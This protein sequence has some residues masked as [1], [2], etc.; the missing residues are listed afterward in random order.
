MDVLIFVLILSNSGD[1][2][3]KKR[4]CRDVRSCENPSRTYLGLKDDLTFSYVSGSTKAKAA[5]EKIEIKGHNGTFYTHIILIQ[6][7][8]FVCIFNEQLWFCLTIGRQKAS[9]IGDGV[10]FYEVTQNALDVIKLGFFSCVMGVAAGCQTR[11]CTPNF[12]GKR[13]LHFCAL[14][15][16]FLVVKTLCFVM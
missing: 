13:L 3:V 14:Q 1:K 8:H 4:D 16:R 11:D 10:T 12:F 15:K 2:A 5:R 9:V 6:S 7:K